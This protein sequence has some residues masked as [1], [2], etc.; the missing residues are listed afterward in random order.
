[1]TVFVSY[2]RHEFNFAEAVAATLRSH[3]ALQPWL[4]VQRLRPGDD[5][6]RKLDQG[7]EDA[8]ALLL[9]ASRAAI[10]SPYVRREWSRALE[11]GIPIYIG[12]VEAVELPDELSDAPVYDLR[13]RF[14]SRTAALGAVIANARIEPTPAAP[15]RNRWGLPSRMPTPVAATATLLAFTAIAFI[16]ATTLMV[17]LDFAVA[18]LVP[19]VFT[20]DSWMGNVSA[21]EG[22]RAKRWLAAILPLLGMT[23]LIALL[24]ASVVALCS[25]LLRRRSGWVSLAVGSG[26]SAMFGLTVFLGVAPIGR[27]PSGGEF[28]STSVME[29]VYPVPPG[30]AADTGVL[31]TLLA[32]GAGCAVVGV[33]LVVS[34]RTLH[35]W[36]PTGKGADHHRG[37]IVQTRRPRWRELRRAMEEF[38]NADQRY[39]P[40][41]QTT[42]F[43][44]ALR[45]YFARGAGLPPSPEQPAVEVVPLAHADRPIAKLLTESCRQAGFAGGASRAGWVLVLVSS[46]VS[47]P[48]AARRI[49]QIG[50]R[51][52]CVLLDNMHLHADAEK[53]RRRQ[54]LDFR[55][56]RPDNLSFLL[57]ALRRSDTGLVE[58]GVSP[59]PIATER[60]RAP[61]PVRWFIAHTI[62]M[63]GFISGFTLTRLI[64]WPLDVRSLALL[65][66]TA[67]LDVTCWRLCHRV[68]TRQITVGRFRRSSWGVLALSAVWAGLAVSTLWT[69]LTRWIGADQ[70]YPPSIIARD[71]AALVAAVVVFVVLSGAGV[72]QLFQRLLR[73]VWLP[74][75]TSSTGR[76]VSGIGTGSQAVLIA[77]CAAIGA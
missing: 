39:I 65:A 20:G 31:R 69:P 77:V 66:A 38:K 26:A 48:E 47:W 54:W 57:F 46:H 15:R 70:E 52:I 12:V 16:W 58:N 73:D 29:Q 72:L 4:D 1:M 53:L 14:W 24:A 74:R 71:Q 67:A 22:L 13:T 41:R 21:L 7:L 11:R 68:T 10:A 27:T 37:R 2:S 25:G 6:E 34:S 76:Q 5:W 30:I 17:N 64:L 51:A 62:S 56:R 8:D 59:T 9:V 61:S 49:E 42:S 18:R 36:L 63:S 40:D 19:D 32:S 45:S 60:F 44:I 50:A 33:I 75:V 3:G 35:L 28:F 23:L 43:L 55:E